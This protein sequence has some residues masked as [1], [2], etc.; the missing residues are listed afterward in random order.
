MEFGHFRPQLAHERTDH[1]A[2]VVI[3]IPDDDGKAASQLRDVMSN[4]NPML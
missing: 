1:V 3:V 2:E 4:D